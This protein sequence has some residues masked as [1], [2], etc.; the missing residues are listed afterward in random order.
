[1]FDIY[2]DEKYDTVLSR[3]D[4]VPILENSIEKYY[5][6]LDSEQDNYEDE[7]IEF[8]SETLNNLEG[9]LEYKRSH[10]N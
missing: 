2:S 7:E 5:R 4:L 8:F 10:M 1:M 3:L 6:M 9:F